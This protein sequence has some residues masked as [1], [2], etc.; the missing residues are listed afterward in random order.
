VTI[1]R[2]KMT[3]Y[4]KLLIALLLALS[5]ATFFFNYRLGAQGE[6]KYISIYV[7]NCFVKEFSFDEQTEE[8]VTFPF[9]ENSEHIATLE[10]GKGRV[11]M[12]PLPENL[13]PQG[14]CSHMGWISHDY[15][16]I[17]CIPN[18]IMVFFGGGKTSDF[19]SITY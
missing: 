2:I 9:G 19:D 11:R 8:I 1:L 14:I 4:D 13:C 12:L 16:S 17:V 15:Q 18:R 6:Q 7:N 5:L 3:I 10:I